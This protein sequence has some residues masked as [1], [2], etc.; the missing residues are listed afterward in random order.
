MAGASNVVQLPCP[1]V[2][3]ISLQ[4]WLQYI[5]TTLFNKD[6]I[7]QYITQQTKHPP[8]AYPNCFPS[9]CRFSFYP[10][11]VHLKFMRSTLR[12]LRAWSPHHKPLMAIDVN[13]SSCEPDITW[14]CINEYIF[15]SYPKIKQTSFHRLN[16]FKK[17][18][19]FFQVG[20]RMQERGLQSNIHKQENILR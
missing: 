12:V 13:K 4:Y 1:A 15:L 7:K 14:A 20:S 10:L 11:E 3:V 2:T 17:P 9:S 19:D 5:Y 6:P 16:Q 18:I 8:C